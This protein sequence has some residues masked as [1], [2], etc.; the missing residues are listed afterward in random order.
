MSMLRIAFLH[1]A[2]APGD[3]SANRRLIERAV[4][5]AAAHGAQWILTSEFCVSGYD[6]VD[7]LGTAWIV[8][9]PDPWMAAVCQ[10]VAH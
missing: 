4:T 9:P 8:P 3:V 1:L 2:P 6:F 10:H 7:R 5:V